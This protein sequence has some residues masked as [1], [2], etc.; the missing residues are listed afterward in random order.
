MFGLSFSGYLGVAGVNPIL[1]GF[2]PSP[3]PALG[4]ALERVA[5]SRDPLAGS[6][7]CSPRSGVTS[8]S[9]TPPCWPGPAE[10]EEPRL[11]QR[12][13]LH[14]LAPAS[15]PRALLLAP[16]WSPSA[17]DDLPQTGHAGQGQDG[18][19]NN[20]AAAPWWAST[21]SH[22]GPGYGLSSGLD[23]LGGI[24]IAPSP[25]S[26]PNGRP[27]LSQGLGGHA[28]AENPWASSWVPDHRA[29]RSRGPP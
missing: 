13:M 25:S 23:G 20:R 14:I 1:A 11:H 3:S 29:H 12:E 22:H 7:G 9:R 8:C 2:S 6:A 28:A 16:A 27:H 21:P 10:N 19:A 18:V 5:V 17:P 24:L 26:S 4:L 15:L